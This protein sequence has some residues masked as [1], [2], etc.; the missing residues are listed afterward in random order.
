MKNV[1]FGDAP[2]F[3]LIS[4]QPQIIDNEKGLLVAFQIIS[5]YS[6]RACVRVL[7]MRVVSV[8]GHHNTSLSILK[9]SIFR[10]YR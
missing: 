9:K 5:V 1:G 6:A 4:S 10:F 3:K 2:N 7:C 8:S